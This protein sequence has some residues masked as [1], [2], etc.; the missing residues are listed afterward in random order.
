MLKYAPNKMSTAVKKWYFELL[1]EGYMGAAA[2]RRVGASTDCGS[3][4]FIDAGSMIVPDPGPIPPRFL[5]QDDR[6]A[7]ADG[8][9]GQA[10]RQS[11]RR[12]DRQEPSNCLPGDPAQQ[13]TRRPL[14]PLVGPQPGAPAQA[15]PQGGEGQG[16]Q[17]LAHNPAREAGR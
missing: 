11:D 13:Q 12:L 9:P 8:P 7:I 2:G 5:T 14:P 10:A 3:L 4:W 6:I 15:A 16:E 17:T 1:R